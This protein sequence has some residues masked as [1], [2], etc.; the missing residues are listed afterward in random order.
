MSQALPDPAI[1]WASQVLPGQAVS[2][3]QDF[4]NDLLNNADLRLI[5]CYPLPALV[6]VTPP[7]FLWE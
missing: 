2:L 7:F 5:G 4:V 6:V 3:M 1:R